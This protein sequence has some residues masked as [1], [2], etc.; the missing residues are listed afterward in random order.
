MA[1][2][3]RIIKSDKTS[4]AGVI[5]DQKE[6]SIV[7]DKRHFISVDERGVSIRG[8]ISIISTGESTRRAG[9]FIG[10]ND[11]LDML[12]S[13]IITPLPKN[14]QNPPYYMMANLA[15]DLSYFLSMLI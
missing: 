11:M 14:I 13:T 9:L 12:P 1:A 10:L 7:G 15:T 2:T 5:V 4:E 6:V 8:P 3:T